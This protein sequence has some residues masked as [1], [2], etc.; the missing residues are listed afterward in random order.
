MINQHIF[1]KNDIR[2]IFPKD[3]STEVVYKIG[4]GYGTY[5]KS[6]FN[7]DITVAI[8]HDARIH[9]ETISEAL[10]KGLSETGIKVIDIGMCPTPVLYFASYVNQTASNN[11]LNLP[12]I[13]GSIMIT[14]SHNPPEYNGLKLLIDKRTLQEEDIN[15]IKDIVMSE[16]FSKTEPKEPIKAEL[17]SIYKQYLISKFNKFKNIKVVIDSANGTA[18][19][20]V[21]SLLEAL[22]CNVIQLFSKPDGNFPFHHPDPSLPENMELLKAIVQDNNFDIGIGYD[23]DSDR[24]GLISPEGK[25][26]WGDDLMI[27]LSREIAKEY[28][29]K[30]ELTF[31]GEVKCSQRM[32]DFIESLGAKPVM[33]K[34]GH[35]FIKQKMKEEKAVLACEM[36][37]HVFFADKYFGYDDA[38]YSTLRILEIIDAYKDSIGESFKID[39]LLENLPELV[40]TPEIRIKSTDEMKFKIIDNIEKVILKDKDK[41]EVKDI[42]TIDGLRIIFNDGFALVRASNTEPILVTR[43]EAKSHSQLNK[44]QKY[45]NELIEKYNK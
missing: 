39:Q 8:G 42:V 27:I 37:G 4:L 31:I 1:R 45:I 18:G 14:G 33:C 44:Y 10:I 29:N 28:T 19:L 11:N 40:S 13:N 16:N 15:K 41:L 20:V 34:T 25:I 3:L 38:I 26:I 6:F 43:F 32:Y 9:S 36:S 2:G 30:S 5:I 24:L 21:P 35:A 7:E 17:N 23:G 22:G 12:E